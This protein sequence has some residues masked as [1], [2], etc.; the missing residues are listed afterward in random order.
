MLFTPRCYRCGVSAASGGEAVEGD[1]WWWL[2]AEKL[3]VG[4]QSDR[5]MERWSVRV[6]LI[7]GKNEKVGGQN[8]S[9]I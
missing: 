3:E 2:V 4:G 5:E 8:D 7:L 9:F 6:V 1:E